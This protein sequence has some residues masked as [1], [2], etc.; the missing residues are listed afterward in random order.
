MENFSLR[1]VLYG[2]ASLLEHLAVPDESR[3]RISCQ[4]KVLR[5]LQAVSR[6][7]FLAQRAEHATRSVEDKL[8]ENFLAARLAGDDDF[9]VH[10]NHV[11]AIFGTGQRAQVT[12]NAKRIVRFRIHV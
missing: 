5:Q 3:A 11:D 8:V 12:S 1:L 10:W 9:D 6:A 2:L 7:S 4:L